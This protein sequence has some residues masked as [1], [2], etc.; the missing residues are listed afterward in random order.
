[1]QENGMCKKA[2]MFFTLVFLTASIG[3]QTGDTVVRSELQAAGYRVTA[4]R[5]QG[6]MPVWDLRT[7]EGLA[8]SL[9][10]IG[11]FSDARAAG[12]ESLL[13]VI[14]DIQG[15]TPDNVRIIFDGDRATAIVIPRR[16]VID[17]DEYR[18][19][20]PSGM[21][22]IYDDAPAYDFR[23]LVDN[24][25]VRV[26]GAFLSERQFLDRIVR[27]VEN[28]AAYIQ[29]SDPQ[30]LAQQI[31]EMQR[32][33]DELSV[34]LAEHQNESALGDIELAGEIDEARQEGA[35]ALNTIVRQ[36]RQAVAAAEN[37]MDG[38]EDEVDTLRTETEENFQSVIA[39]STVLADEF[40][41][42][43]QGS[44][45]LA[46]RNIF[47]SLK[48]VDPDTVEQLVELRKNNPDLLPAD[49]L[50]R[51]NESLPEGEAPLHKKHVQAV[52]A[53]FFNDYR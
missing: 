37:R 15:L 39:E 35:A 24:L 16:F 31:Q 50:T 9:A 2:L 33:F 28:P 7:E 5:T 45:I 21:Q 13:D 8:F 17:G 34:R 27:A 1:M 19:Y 25:A 26:N 29:S 32:L 18:S 11:T 44:V 42:M 49:A 14:Q 10:M 20:M 3:A 22:F 43:R 40:A 38:I 48:E 51:V 53:F 23:M 30:Y 36:G 12:V 4:S 46:T 41:R 6:G 52:Y 47:G